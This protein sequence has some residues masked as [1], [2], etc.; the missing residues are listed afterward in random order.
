[1]M[2][3]PSILLPLPAPG[4]V[5]GSRM[6]PEALMCKGESCTQVLL[7]VAEQKAGS[8]EG[9]DRGEQRVAGWASL[10]KQAPDGGFT[11]CLR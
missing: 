5:D 9:A 3:C 1:M 6:N 4:M 10:G 8:T 7:R 2:G 11:C